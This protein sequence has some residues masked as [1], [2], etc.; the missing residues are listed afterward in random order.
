MGGGGPGPHP[1]NAH[2]H[3]EGRLKVTCGTGVSWGGLSHFQG[4]QQPIIPVILEG[5][6]AAGHQVRKG[7]VVHAPPPLDP[8]LFWAHTD[9]TGC[10]SPSR[11]L[12]PREQG[13]PE[14]PR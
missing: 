12:C 4:T 6:P 8:P 9:V 3:S 2:R 14:R 1:G 7:Q 13:A 5:H 10:P 11:R